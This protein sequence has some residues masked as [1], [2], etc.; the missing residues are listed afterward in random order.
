MS[1][2][3]GVF[4]DDASTSASEDVSVIV[5]TGIG[6]CIFMGMCDLSKVVRHC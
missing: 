2:A 5:D 3:V 4:E 6:L 1:D